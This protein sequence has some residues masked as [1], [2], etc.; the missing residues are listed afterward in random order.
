M[1]SGAYIQ[2]S[3][4]TTL[5]ECANWCAQTVECATWTFYAAVRKCW[6]KS[7]AHP[8]IYYCNDG[9]CDGDAFVSGTKAC[10]EKP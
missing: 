2:E 1:W 10:G 9:N 8:Y 5:N 4:K 6:L 7:A 3:S